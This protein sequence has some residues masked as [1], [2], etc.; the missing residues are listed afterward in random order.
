MPDKREPQKDEDESITEALSSLGWVEEREEGEKP[1]S[2]EENLKEQLD[3]FIEQN[4]K[5]NDQ[6]IKLSEE[7]EN[8]KKDY[9]FLF[10]EKEKF[11]QMA[12]QNNNTIENLLQTIVQKDDNIK[13]LELKAEALSQSAKSDLE[14]SQVIESK[15]KENLELQKQYE[16]QKQQI[17]ELEFSNNEKIQIVENQKAEIDKLN[18]IIQDQTQKI[19]SLTNEME[20]LKSEQTASQGLVERLNEKD[21]KIKE[22]M[23]Q[24]QYLEK[25]TVQ[26]SK[27]EKIKLL[28]EKKDEIITEKEKAIFEMQNSME[29]NNKKIKELQQQV[30]TFSLVKKDL[31]KKEERIKELVLEVEKSTQKNKTN[32]EF[33]NRI[34]KQLEESQ[35]KS[36]NI[37]GKFE[38]EMANLRSIIDDQNNEIKELKKQ[39]GNIKNKLYEAEQIED[40][41]LGEMQKVKDSKL[42]LESEIKIKIKFNFINLF[43]APL[44]SA[45]AT[46]VFLAIHA[47][48]IQNNISFIN[49]FMD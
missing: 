40:R 46:F 17:E 5:L 42:K 24:I 11:Q 12:D 29:S 34:E 39:E 22:L 48:I 13:E 37:T 27:F 43:L 2:E 7:L 44:Y 9:E 10:Q 3:E 20:Q 28:V 15:D 45:K 30:E 31:E 47:W 33:M 32:E 6:L 38:L 49:S 4:R 8:S 26:K 1:V 21:S 36:G 35:E 18:N 19:K 16:T 14:M 25:D 41:I 23:E